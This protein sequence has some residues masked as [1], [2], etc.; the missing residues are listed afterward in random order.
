VFK[1]ITP[2]GVIGDPTAAS[3]DKGERLLEAATNAIAK[4][5]SDAAR[6][7]MPPA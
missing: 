6:W 3:A 4:V 7:T 1:E 5:L 2:S